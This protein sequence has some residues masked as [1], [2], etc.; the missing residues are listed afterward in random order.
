[1][2]R[3]RRRRDSFLITSVPRA[4]PFPWLSLPRSISPYREIEDRRYW[5]PDPVAPARSFSRSRHRLTVSSSRPSRQTKAAISFA[6]PRR[7]LVCV[8]RQVRKEVLFATRRNG[9]NGG[10]NYRRNAYSEVSCR[11]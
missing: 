8:R 2:A 6:S 9:R 5:H 7:V 10:R 3:S 1:M 11:S 4:L